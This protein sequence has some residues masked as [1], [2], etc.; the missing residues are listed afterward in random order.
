MIA[1]RTLV[2]RTGDSWPTTTTGAPGCQRSTSESLSARRATRV[3]PGPEDLDG[4]GTVARTSRRSGSIARATTT[5]LTGS[6]ISGGTRR[7]ASSV[8]T[9]LRAS[10]CRSLT[11]IELRTVGGRAGAVVERKTSDTRVGFALAL[12]VAYVVVVIVATLA[13]ER[14]IS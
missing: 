5:T 13:I 8:A 11:P 6:G 10:R 1:P 4:T 9:R 14:A 2:A 3:A 12:L 7:F